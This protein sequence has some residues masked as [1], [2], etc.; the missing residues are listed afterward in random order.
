MKMKMK[1]KMKMNNKT[2]LVTKNQDRRIF[3][4]STSYSYSLALTTRKFPSL[5]TNNRIITF[6]KVHYLFMNASQFTSTDHLFHG[7]IFV[8]GSTVSDIFENG[9]VKENRLL[10]NHPDLTS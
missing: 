7:D 9:F 3:N 10:T 2:C 8:I 1:M 4:Q 6:G 5:L